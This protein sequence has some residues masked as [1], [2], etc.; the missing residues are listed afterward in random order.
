MLL[1]V[2]RGPIGVV[3]LVFLFHLISVCIKIGR[4]LWRFSEGHGDGVSFAWTV[5]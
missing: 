5:G 3:C 4:I 1:Q 2:Y